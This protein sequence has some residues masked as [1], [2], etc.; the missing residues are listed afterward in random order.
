LRA[1]FFS[2]KIRPFHEVSPTDDVPP[3]ACR[4][5]IPDHPTG[6]RKDV[7]RR[8]RS[9]GMNFFQLEEGETR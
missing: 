5:E 2:G 9:I 6:I 1:V 3:G 4:F 8:S 7:R